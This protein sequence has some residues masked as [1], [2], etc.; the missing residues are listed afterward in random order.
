VG[1]RLAVFRWA[2]MPVR[3]RDAR[4]HANA[5]ATAAEI[6]RCCFRLSAA[7]GRGGAKSA[8]SHATGHSIVWYAACGDSNVSGGPARERR[9]CMPRKRTLPDALLVTLGGD[10]C[11]GPASA[12]VRQR[13]AGWR[14]GRR[15]GPT[16]AGTT[17]MPLARSPIVLG[18]P[19]A[20]ASIAACGSHASRPDPTVGTVASHVLRTTSA[21]SWW[22][23]ATTFE[24]RAWRK[25]SLNVGPV[26]FLKAK[27]LARAPIQPNTSVKIRT[28]VHPGTQVTLAMAKG[29][30]PRHAGQ[31]AATGVDG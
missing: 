14:V 28:P 25:D 9:I 20:A 5:P 11:N 21:Q 13:L 19:L 3:L 18:V 16:I 30:P 22:P 4:A 15:H 12:S 10:A 7:L 6:A 31:S 29:E 1:E 2:S 23:T 27:R 26:T 24:N 17:A 8:A